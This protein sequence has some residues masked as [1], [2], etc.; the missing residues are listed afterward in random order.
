MNG[1]GAY[2]YADSS[3]EGVELVG[4][5]D[6]QGVPLDPAQRAAYLDA[7]QER[8]EAGEIDENTA[9]IDGENEGIEMSTTDRGQAGQGEQQGVEESK[10]G[11]QPDLD[12]DNP[13]IQNV[14]EDALEKNPELSEEQLI[15]GL[16]SGEL[17]IISAG[18]LEFG[19]I[20]GIAM[21]VTRLALDEKTQQDTL[22]TGGDIGLDPNKD[23]DID[24]VVSDTNKIVEDSTGINPYDI[25][26]NT[27]KAIVN[28]A[29]A[30]G[31]AIADAA[32][33]TAKVFNPKNWI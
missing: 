11:E 2:R 23:A 15:A 5:I 7:E 22:D 26:P 25:I 33:A 18:G 6:R 17:D 30:T 3:T 13:E 12:L 1:S 29:E 10:E 28:V 21:Y 8:F 31:D 19:A 16:S 32:K 4:L 27:E 14:I 9:L 24:A 20:T